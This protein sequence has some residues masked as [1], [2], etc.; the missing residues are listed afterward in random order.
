LILNE[1]ALANTRGEGIE[2]SAFKAKG[3]G[4][5][6][7]R[8]AVPGAGVRAGGR[9]PAPRMGGNGALPLAVGGGCRFEYELARLEAGRSQGQ[10]QYLDADHLVVGVLREPFDPAQD[11]PTG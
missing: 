11:R 9:G 3:R 7:R 5:M 1:V 8:G 10:L 2:P 4:R 6:R